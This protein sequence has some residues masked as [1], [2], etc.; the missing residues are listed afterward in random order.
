[1][2]SEIWS[3][4]TGGLD[5]PGTIWAG[6]I[7]SALFRSDDRGATWR[8]MRGQSKSGWDVAGCWVWCMGMLETAIVIWWMA[9]GTGIM[10]DLSQGAVITRVMLWLMSALL[11][12]GILHT[13]RVPD[14]GMALRRA[15]QGVGMWL[16]VGLACVAVSL[17]FR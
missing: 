2:L 12:V 13:R 7:P 15:R 9:Y 1:M 6:T 5:E 4:E 16:G 17:W 3:L 8:M 10:D 14:F 11:A